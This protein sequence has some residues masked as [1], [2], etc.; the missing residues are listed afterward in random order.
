[1]GLNAV[2][3]RKGD[4]DSGAVL[5][6]VMRGSEGFLVYSQVRD[7]NARLAW[8]C[9]TGAV[10]VPEAAADQIIAKAI[11]VDWDIWVVEIED[12]SGAVSI[13]ENILGA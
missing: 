7:A 1:M 11:D 5:I 10:P 4:E 8:M 9:V 13:L 3:A 6:K 2:V 12:R